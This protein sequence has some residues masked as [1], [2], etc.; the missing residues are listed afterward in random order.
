MIS[1][2][3]VRCT[4]L[5][6]N[7]WNLDSEFIFANHNILPL[8][9]NFIFFLLVVAALSRNKGATK[10]FIC[11]ARNFNHHHT[12]ASQQYLVKTNI[13]RQDALPHPNR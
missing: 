7:T 2:F 12:P 11:P 10:S 13:A 9:R 3:G 6:L 4:Y 8:V 5:E 1:I